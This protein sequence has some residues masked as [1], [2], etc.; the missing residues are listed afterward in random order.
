MAETAKQR[1]ELNAAN[2]PAL[3][4]RSVTGSLELWLQS[5]FGY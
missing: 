4:Q 5:E 2:R 3:T 1:Y